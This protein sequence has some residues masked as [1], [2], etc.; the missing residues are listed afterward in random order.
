M[1]VPCLILETEIQRVGL[2]TCGLALRA[3]HPLLSPL[4]SSG[5]EGLQDSWA[6]CS[7]DDIWD[8]L[9][10]ILSLVKINSPVTLFLFFEF[11]YLR[12]REQK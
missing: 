12:A 5:G 9:G 8:M 7:D 4:S 3:G 1:A 6:K 11:T 2:P 10:C